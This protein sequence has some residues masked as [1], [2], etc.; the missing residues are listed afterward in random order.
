MQDAANVTSITQMI[1]SVIQEISYLHLL[2]SLKI[3]LDSGLGHEMFDSN[4]ENS[5]ILFTKIFP[6]QKKEVSNIFMLSIETR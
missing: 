1:C 3:L 2:C 5:L 6:A 4:A